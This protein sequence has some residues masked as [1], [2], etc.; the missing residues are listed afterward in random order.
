M[1]HNFRRRPPTLTE[2]IS[3]L[4]EPIADDASEDERNSKASDDVS[5]DKLIKSTKKNAKAAA[6]SKGKGKKK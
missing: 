5:N 3:Q 6:G 1:R 2:R 4:D